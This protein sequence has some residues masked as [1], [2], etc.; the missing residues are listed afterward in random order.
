[1]AIAEKDIWGVWGLVAFEMTT[2]D[3][4]TSTPMGDRPEGRLIYTQGGYMSAHLGAPDRPPMAEMGEAAASQALAALK[5]HFSYSGRYRIEGDE[6]LHAVDLSISPDW[7][8]TT[9]R[10]RIAF[11]GDDLILVD[12]TIEPRFG[13]KTGVGRLVW[14]REE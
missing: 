7:P 2:T 13:R 12:E 3:G 1:M 10:R 6:V 5:T 4:E 14:R 11:E 8:G 9:K